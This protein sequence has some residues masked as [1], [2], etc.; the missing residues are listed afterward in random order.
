M[1]QMDRIDLN[2]IRVNAQETIS[3]VSLA[4]VDRTGEQ[5]VRS[6]EKNLSVSSKKKP[7]RSVQ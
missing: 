7:R 6:S 2:F 3:I 5:S 4:G 1:D